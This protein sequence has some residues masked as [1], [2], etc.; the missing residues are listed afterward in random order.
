MIM[1]YLT[2]VLI[3]TS[4]SG[5]TKVYDV[6]N[7]QNAITVGQIKWFGRFRKYCFFPVDNMVFDA[8]CLT[9]ISEFLLKDV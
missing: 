8:T 4:D 3:G 5:K 9:A 6:V 2:L 7:R 1:N